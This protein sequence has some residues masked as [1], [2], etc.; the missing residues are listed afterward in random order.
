MAAVMVMALLLLALGNT[1]A[2]AASTQPR[3]FN[4]PVDMDALGGAPDQS[5]LNQP[6]DAASRI[7]AHDGHF[8]TVG[9]DG[10]PG[11]ADDRRIRL[12]GVNLSLGANF[13]EADD[14]ARL[15]R[16]LRKLGVNAVRLHHLDLLPSDY[17]DAPLSILTSGPYPTFSPTAVARLRGLV[18]AL[19][20]EGIYV[21][22]NLHV[23]YR[24]RPRVDKLPP[25]DGGAEQPPV[26]APIHL[27]YPSLVEKQERYARELIQA[28]NLKGNPVLAMVE[29]NNESSLVTAWLG[30]EWQ[31][32]VPSGYAPALQRLWREW[33]LRRYGTLDQAC[34]AWGGCASGVA[35]ADELPMPG[36][37]QAYESGLAA[38]RSSIE[39]RARKWFGGKQDGI[40]ARE[41]D[42]LAFLTATDKTYFDRLRH[43]VHE[44]TD[45]W[46]PVTGTQMTFGGIL[47]FDSQPSMDF[48]DEHIYVAHPDL[49]GDHDWRIEDRTAS[50]GDFER[51]LAVS[52]R[53]DRARPFVVSEYN[54]PFP[55][56]RGAEILP[57]MSAVAAL[58]DWDALFYFGYS[59]TVRTP[60]SPS[61]FS[62]VGDWGRVALVGQ[63]ASLF[64]LGLLPALTRH[65]D[66]PVPAA[67]RG[68][69]GADRRFDAIT[70]GLYDTLGAR[71]QLAYQGQVALQLDPPENATPA[72]P[73]VADPATAKAYATPDGALR[74]DLAAGRIVIDTPLFWA[75]AG[76]TG[77]PRI[78]GRSAWIQY[79]QDGPDSATVILSPLD[80]RTL[81][82][83]R[84]LLLSLGNFTTG[85]QPGS[86]PQ[87]PKRVVPYGGQSRWSTLEPDP[88]AGGPSGSTD[89]RPPAWLLATPAVLGLAPRSGQLKVYPLDGSGRRLAALAPSLASN[90]ADGARI[91]VQAPPQAAVNGGVNK[92]DGNKQDNNK[93]D[94][95]WYEIVYEDKP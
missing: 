9:R 37:Q 18:Q 90:A 8:Y 94:S 22:L 47:N 19:A 74:Q 21:D 13:P 31:A 66:I 83:S 29:L 57:L 54:Q 89:T 34:T 61:R 79:D 70:A 10:L 82:D 6:L 92:Q 60:M 3:W 1:G 46:V 62:L 48:I 42:F 80:G 87:R 26:T 17:E 35:Q 16:D 15:A 88:G 58:Q 69:L 14:A 73:A 24:F 36:Q 41:R 59:D 44:A 38:V 71:P 75:V 11:T 28:L 30:N 95:I 43:V 2:Q 63:S 76:A 23:G 33:L 67:L 68:T 86:M 78:A 81:A 7:V 93:Q 5:A 50:G 12:F 32:A 56:P 4:F 39:R 91:H 72:L 49:H 64:R 77:A 84:H 53:R 20:R 65:I 52:M 45:K 51:L 27:Y 40:D 55:N 85:S 25:L